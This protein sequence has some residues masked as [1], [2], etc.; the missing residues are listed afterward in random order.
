MLIL[1]RAVFQVKKIFLYL[2]LVS[3]AAS[4]QLIGLVNNGK[5][6]PTFYR[7]ST[8]SYTGYA[9]SKKAGI[10]NPEPTFFTNTAEDDNDN[11]G[12]SNTPFGGVS[13]QRNMCEWCS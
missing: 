4:R 9:W 12:L 13:L 5:P 11:G 7:W 10:V 1:I 8:Y 3:L 2:I 6:N